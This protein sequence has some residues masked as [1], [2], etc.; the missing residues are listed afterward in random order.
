MSTAAETKRSTRVSAAEGRRE[1][2]DII[3]SA[4]A[5]EERRLNPFLLD[6][7]DS[8]ALADRYFPHWKEVQDLILDARTMNALSRVVKMQEGRLRYQ[9]QLFHADPEA[10][11]EKLDKFDAKVLGKL[12]L[13]AWHPIVELE[14]LTPEALE[15]ALDYWDELPTVEARRRE[16]PRKEPPPVESVTLDDLLARGILAR[17]GFGDQ[18]AERWDDLKARGSSDYYAFVDAPTHAERIQRAYATSYLITYGYA[19][20][21]Q[22]DGKLE[23]KP[24]GEREPPQQSVSLPLIV[25]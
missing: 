19:T 16:R 24:R 12:F 8:L 18:L 10:M 3:K 22:T 6:I 11:A 23:L 7:S 20:L 25:R 2:L 9:A 21:S 17:D 15:E 5:T 14:Q 1:L 13:E 4:R